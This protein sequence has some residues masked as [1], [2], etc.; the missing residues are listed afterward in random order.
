MA[1]TQILLSLLAINLADSSEVPQPP[2]TFLVV[3]L[4]LL[5]P[6]PSLPL[7]QVANILLVGASVSEPPFMMSMTLMYVHV[8]TCIHMSSAQECACAKITRDAFEILLSLL[9]D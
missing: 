2:S 4:L 6:T 3:L 1:C 9:A 5:L 8:R 7:P